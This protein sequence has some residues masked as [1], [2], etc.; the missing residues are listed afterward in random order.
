MAEDGT[1]AAALMSDEERAAKAQKREREQRA[2]DLLRPETRGEQ[3]SEYRCAACKGTRC[4]LFHTN[5]MGAVHLTSVPDMI[6]ECLDCG[7]RFTL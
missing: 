1:L 5:S 7:H 4:N 2:I 6:I 3:S